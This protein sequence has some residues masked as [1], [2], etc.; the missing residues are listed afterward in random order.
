MTSEL[1]FISHVYLEVEG[2]RVS[3][4]LSQVCLILMRATKLPKVVKAKH[5]MRTQILIKMTSP[6]FFPFLIRP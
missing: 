5:T 6:F 2:S 1:I 4:K 3:I